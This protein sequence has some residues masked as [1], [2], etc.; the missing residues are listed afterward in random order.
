[1]RSE[2]E[3]RVEEVKEVVKELSGEGGS[4]KKKERLMDTATA[5]RTFSGGTVAVAEEWLQDL[6]QARKTGK[7]SEDYTK[8]VLY[9]KLVGS[10]KWWQRDHGSKLETF[11]E[12]KAGFEKAYIPEEN[13]TI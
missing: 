2:R 11:V 12:W 7:W 5:L 1:M 6:E 9:A 3:K 8:S 4:E 10:A 13:E